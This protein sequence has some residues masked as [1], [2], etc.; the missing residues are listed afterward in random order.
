MAAETFP[1]SLAG[2]K[3]RVIAA[4]CTLYRHDWD[5]LDVDANER[6]ITHKLAEYLQ[7][8]F[9]GWNVDCEYNRLGYDPKR[10]RVASWPVRADDTEAKTVF[11]DIIIHRRKTPDHNLIVIE[12][13]KAGGEEETKDKEKLKAFTSTDEYEYDYG[14]FL[15]LAP[16]GNSE[17]TLHRKR[18]R[19]T[20][21]T[22]D[23]QRA[24]QELG[25][26]G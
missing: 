13:K 9:P 22:G 3:R 6:S 15:R 7:R 24:L 14:L 21:W 16:D 23:L 19:P 10:L 20:D 4:I 1:P 12:V 11:P 18:S 25:Y 5:L 2:V 17:I 8:E 26:G